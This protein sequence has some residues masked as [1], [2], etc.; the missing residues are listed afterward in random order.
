MTAS[1]CG[2]FIVLGIAEK[3]YV[4]QTCTGKLLSVIGRHYQDVTKVAFTDDGSHFVSC[5]ADGNTFVWSLLGA[6]VAHKLPGLFPFNCF[7]IICKC[8]L[9]IINTFR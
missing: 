8:K 6:T 1:P 9:G 2:R 7:L 4:Y 5:G 3:L